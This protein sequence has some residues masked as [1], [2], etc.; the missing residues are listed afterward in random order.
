MEPITIITLLTAGIPFLTAAIK[1]ILRTEKW[2]EDHRKGWHGLIPIVLGILSTGLYEKSRGSDWV[3]AL[4]V[5]LGSG[6]AAS[7]ARDLDKNLVQVFSALRSILKPS[8]ED[9]PQD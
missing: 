6:G 2:P 7:S 4:A 3:T 8:Q 9:H 5:G 1:K